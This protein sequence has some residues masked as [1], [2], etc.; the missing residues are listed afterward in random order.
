M[1]T[2]AQNQTITAVCSPQATC[3]RNNLP[4]LPSV[5]HRR[6]LWKLPLTTLHNYPQKKNLTKVLR[7]NRAAQAE[8]TAPYSAPRFRG[9]YSGELRIKPRARQKVQNHRE[10]FRKVHPEGMR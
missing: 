5:V 1:D 9:S 4:L 6:G 3:R 2:A 10:N 8:V 7:H